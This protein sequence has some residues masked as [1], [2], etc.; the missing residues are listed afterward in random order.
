MRNK[1]NR[2]NI[3]STKL[4]YLKTEIAKNKRKRGLANTY[5]IAV[6]D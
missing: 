4:V 6:N 2:L 3:H 1:L 5:L